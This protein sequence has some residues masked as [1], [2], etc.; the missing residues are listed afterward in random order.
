MAKTVATLLGIGF[1]VIGIAGLFAP[2]FLGAH[3]SMT[4]NLIHLLSGVAALWVGARGTLRGARSFSYA[5]GTLY[6]LLGVL[7]FVLGTPGAST[8]GH[9]GPDARLWSVIPGALELGTSDHVIHLV[10]GGLFLLAAIVTRVPG[11]IAV[12]AAPP[13]A[14]TPGP[15]EVPPPPPPRGPE[16]PPPPAGV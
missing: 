4:H 10:I 1:I 13:R 16:A 6:G 5:F 14:E 8:A 7:G 15:P 12:P 9:T 2:G 3:L 11:E